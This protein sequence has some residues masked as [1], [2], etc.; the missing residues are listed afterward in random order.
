MLHRLPHLFWTALF[1]LTTASC[2]QTPVPRDPGGSVPYNAV[3]QLGT[4][5]SFWAEHR[6]G[7]PYANGPGEPLV[8]QLLADQARS[9][10]ID[11]HPGEL[12][13]LR[14]HS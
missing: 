11:I 3:W 6:G 10:E 9:I 5:N 13:V 2:S 1:L 4:H 12:K 8:D 7:D 14:P